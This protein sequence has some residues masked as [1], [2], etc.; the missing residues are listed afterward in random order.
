MIFAGGIAENNPAYDAEPGLRE[1]GPSKFGAM[2]QAL[3]K[4]LD[5]RVDNL[6]KVFG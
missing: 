3:V 5:L 1:I 6:E 4:I 2:R